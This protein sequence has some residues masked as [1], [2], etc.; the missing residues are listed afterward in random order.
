MNADD[1]DFSL[2]ATR[3]PHSKAGITIY[4]VSRAKKG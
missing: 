2:L 4:F 1:S 3:H